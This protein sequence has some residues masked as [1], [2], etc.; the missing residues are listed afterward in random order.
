MST[1]MRTV[2]AI[3]KDKTGLKKI[4]SF[5]MQQTLDTKLSFIYFLFREL[6]VQNFKNQKLF[7]T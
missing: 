7:W 3:T 4:N 1:F 6:K 2:L 5:V